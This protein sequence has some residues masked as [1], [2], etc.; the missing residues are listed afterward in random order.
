MGKPSAERHWQI[1]RMKAATYRLLGGPALALSS[2][3]LMGA[4]TPLAKVLLGEVAP[5]PLAGLL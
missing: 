1:I 4:S 3:A 2:A 5:W